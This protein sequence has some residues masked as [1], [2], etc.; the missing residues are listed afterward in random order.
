VDE[1]LQTGTLEAACEHAWFA[2]HPCHG[3]TQFAAKVRDSATTHMA[4]FNAFQVRPDTLPG[5]QFRRI[6][7]QALQ[8]E[9]LGRP[10]R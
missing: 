7:R 6:G 1:E 3:I 4:P 9:A 2:S 10:I 5:V 8:V